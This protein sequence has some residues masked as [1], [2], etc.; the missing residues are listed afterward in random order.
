MSSE[1]QYVY[2]CYFVD[3]SAEKGGGILATSQT[4]MLIEETSFS[5]CKATSSDGGGLYFETTGSCV[6]YRVCSFACTA[7]SNGPFCSIK[8]QNS[9][10]YNNT[11]KDSSVA[12]SNCARR[13]IWLKYGMILAS[14]INSSKNIADYY[15]NLVYP[16]SSCDFADCLISF[17]CF[18]NNEVRVHVCVLYDSGGKGEMRSCNVINNTQGQKSECGVVYTNSPL[19]IYNSCVIGNDAD[20][21]F[22]CSGSYKINLYNTTFDKTSNYNAVVQSSAATT[23]INNLLFIKTGECDAE[24]VKSFPKSRKTYD[25][26]CTVH[27]RRSATDGLTM[28]KLSCLILI[29]Y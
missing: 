3:C 9:L 29:C 11:M 23:F 1:S 15:P 8:L 2:C 14:S 28:F 21:A 19:N 24:D 10:S 12:N 16:S 5:S 4:N 7:P 6:L 18:S 22:Y 13:T 20:R 25:K 26:A 27:Y 17:S